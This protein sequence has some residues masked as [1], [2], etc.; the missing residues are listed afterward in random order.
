MK[1]LLAAGIALAFSLVAS[2]A[3]G[4]NVTIR[5]STWKAMEDALRSIEATKALPGITIEFETID[6]AQMYDRY[7]VQLPA[8]EGA[9]VIVLQSGAPVVQFRQFMVPVNRYLQR[10]FGANWKNDWDAGALAQATVG[11]DLVGVPVGNILAGTIWYNKETFRKYNIKVPTTYA[12]LKA[13]AQTLRKNGLLPL[14]QGA[15][16]T[17]INLDVFLALCNDIN[18]KA[19]YDAQEG[20]ASW[21]APDIVKALKAWK[22]LFADGVFQDGAVGISQYMDA[23]DL[24]MDGK[25][26]MIMQ[27]SWNITP[28]TYDAWKDRFNALERGFFRWPDM[29]GDGKPAPLVGSLDQIFCI[30]KNTKNLEAAWKVVKELTTGNAAS[31]YYQSFDTLPTYKKIKIDMSS[32]KPEMKENCLQVIDYQKY[33]V[34]LRQMKYP[35]LEKAVADALMLVATT[36]T[37]PE[38]ALANVQSVSKSIKR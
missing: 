31:V 22:G 10:D 6:P 11:N 30:N 7:R 34:G 2:F 16:D 36:D 26:A 27:G 24:W 29:N 13:A 37:A 23:Q 8:G 38:V 4:Q 5:Y 17:W 25:A 20:K 12:E 28:Y 14:V 21:T 3:F 1:R 15:K 32:F 19:F 33:V 18:P 9:D 35:E